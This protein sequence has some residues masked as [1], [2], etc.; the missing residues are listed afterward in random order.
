MINS[1]NNLFEWII[2]LV[3]KISMIQPDEAGVRVTLGKHVKKLVPGWY[4]NWPVIHDITYVTTTS[5]VVDVRVQSCLTA[6]LKDVCVGTAV[7]YQVSDAEK[8]I[9]KV[10]DYDRNIRSLVLGVT[11]RYMSQNLFEELGDIE[12]LEKTILADLR[13]EAKGWGLKINKVYITDIGLTK[14]YRI[15]G[16][17]RT[18]I[19]GDETE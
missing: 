13:D 14:N 5:Q 16:N 3:P 9:L 7:K 2:N 8:A 10:D 6:D 1:L 11:T 18:V 15:L 4:F 19:D 17:D 12:D